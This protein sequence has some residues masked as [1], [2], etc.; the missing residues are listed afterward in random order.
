MFRT[1]LSKIQRVTEQYSQI[2][3]LDLKGVGKQT[4]EFYA[5]VDFT[6]LVCLYTSKKDPDGILLAQEMVREFSTGISSK[7]ACLKIDL[8]N[9]FDSVLGNIL[10]LHYQRGH[11]LANLLTRVED[12]Y[13][14]LL[15]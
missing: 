6:E 3:A 5:I 1:K 10:L 12:V 2:H 13:R 4:R 15:C 9:A 8:M 11:L 14:I 7:R